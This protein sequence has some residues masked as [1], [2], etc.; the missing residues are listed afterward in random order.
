ME[1]P[2]AV[3]IAGG[4][5]HVISQIKAERRQLALM[6]LSFAAVLA[7]FGFFLA[8]VTPWIP[9]GLTADAY[10]TS[11]GVAILL[12]LVSS[13]AALAFVVVWSPV[14]RREPLPEF[15][16]VLFGGHRLIRRPEQFY[17][18]LG[19]ECRRVHRD[20]RQAFSLIILRLANGAAHHGQ[21]PDLAA[22]VVRSL[23]RADDIVANC[24][25]DEVWLL[26]ARADARTVERVVRRLARA[27]ASPSIV[28][29]PVQTREIGS[30][31]I[32]RDGDKPD[33]LFSVARQRLAPVRSLDEAA[34]A[35]LTAGRASA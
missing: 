35:D 4:V 5:P 32:G 12:A 6:R 24:P 15:L 31:T 10:G 7:L 3:T 9:F 25:P 19:A 23:V 28:L 13:F 27:L 18:R 8:W 34:A 26:I 30:S 22:I 29:G 17:S 16:R 14:F 2:E 20:R 1:A 11:I 33:V 21:H